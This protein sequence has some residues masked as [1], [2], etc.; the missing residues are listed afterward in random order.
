MTQPDGWQPPY[1]PPASNGPD[2][3]SPE[4]PS[5]PAPPEPYQSHQ[6][7]PYQQQPY[8]PQPY[9][10]QPAQQQPAQPSPYQPQPGAQPGQPPAYGYP[11]QTG[12]YGYGAPLPKNPLGVWS[13]VLG[14]VGVVL[15]C[16]CGA[17]FLT[18]IPAVITGHLSRKAQRE[19]QA[20][21][22]NLGL[23]GLIIGYV[24]VGLTVLGLIGFG[25]MFSIPEF[26]EGFFSE[27][28]SSGY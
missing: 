26:R 13:L 3:P 20:D 14:I 19:G 21:N 25:A 7:S 4:Q 5:P 18:A 15:M 16:S 28:N 22:G 27:M 8:Q 1:E 23:V 11:P 12:P 17:G 2:Q 10:Q 9:Q 6:S 24:V